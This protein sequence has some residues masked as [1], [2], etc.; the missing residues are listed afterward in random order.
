MILPPDL[1][2][3]PP[4]EQQDVLDA[5][6]RQSLSAFIQKSFGVV[7]AG[8][9]YQHNWHIDLIAQHLEAC[10]RG[11]IK[12]LIINIPPRNLKSICAAIAFPAWMLRHDPTRK[13]ISVSY[14][15]D[16]SSRHGMDCRRVMESAFYQRIFPATRISREKNTQF[17][18]IT[19]RG[20]GR[21]ST[22]VSGT[23]TGRGGD[24]LIIDD[25][26]K[27]GDALS[28]SIRSSTNQWYDHTLYSRLNS[29][30]E[31]VIII[32]MQRLHD[33]DLV[34]H[35]LG[36]EEWVHLKI[37]AICEEPVTIPVGPQCV[38]P[39]VIQRQLGHVLHSARES[40]AQLEKLRDEILGSYVFAAQYQQEPAPLGGGLIKWHWLQYYSNLP[41]QKPKRIV[42]SW[43]TAIKADTVHDYS[44]CTTWHEYDHAYYLIDVQRLRLEFPDLKKA[45]IAQAGIHLPHAILIEDK[46]SGT[47][48]IQEIKQ[49]YSLPVIGVVPESDKIARALAQTP[50]MEAGK[51]LLPANALLLSEFQNELSKFPNARHDDQ[52]DSMTQ[53]LSWMSRPIPRAC[54]W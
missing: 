12:R 40:K 50:K 52:V 22:S 24:I 49:E 34:G 19:T 36:Q 9:I 21:M 20:G 16:L 38:R 8:D 26:I 28:E 31:G 46:R 53:A 47:S 23:L 7:S 42:Q 44:V 10:A 48:L 39:Y 35:V 54:V 17:E 5:L 11:E 32:I 6:L 15:Q 33:D 2:L 51:V 37:P 43:D 30:S 4:P 45:I 41:A 25:P 29:R 3:L 14:A 1:E 13:I 18:F 27:P